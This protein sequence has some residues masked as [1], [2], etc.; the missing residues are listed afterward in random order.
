MYQNRLHKLIYPTCSP[1]T[2]NSWNTYVGLFKAFA[3][4][5]F[6]LSPTYTVHRVHWTFFCNDNVL[7]TERGKKQTYFQALTT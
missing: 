7:P 1:C 2:W 6:C 3:L 4:I 5:W